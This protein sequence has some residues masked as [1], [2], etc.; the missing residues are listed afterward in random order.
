MGC[1]RAETDCTNI[2]KNSA[3]KMK[4]NQKKRELFMDTICKA[5]LFEII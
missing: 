5:M 4:R 1:A 3:E 2:D